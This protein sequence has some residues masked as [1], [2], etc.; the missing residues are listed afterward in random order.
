MWNNPA[1][2][3]RERKR[4]IALLVTDVTLT[5]AQEQITLG[6][7]FRGGTTTTLCLPVPLNA[8][9]KRQTHPT[10]LAR[11]E[12]LLAAHTDGEVASALNAEGFTT[13]AGAP[14]N[15]P[16]VRWLQHRWKIK[17]YREH[18]RDAG[19]LTTAE[20]AARLGLSQR[21]TR[22]WRGAGRLLATPYNDRRDRLFHPV[23]R[24]PPNIQ[25]RVSG[26]EA[27]DADPRSATAVARGAV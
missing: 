3:Q 1:V 18:L 13:G 16:A 8:W 21:Q 26:L 6:V 5:K 25:A 20:M 4:M 24:Q 22:D 27:G 17:S 9:R 23:E 12:A 19:H 15:A 7:R 11:L 2:P 14:F 10:A